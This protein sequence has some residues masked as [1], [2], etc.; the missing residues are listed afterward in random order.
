MASGIYRSLFP[1]VSHSGGRRQDLTFFSIHFGSCFEFA[2]FFLFSR[3]LSTSRHNVCAYTTCHYSAIC[4]MAR[5]SLSGIAVD[6]AGLSR[7]IDL[8]ATRHHLQSA[9]WVG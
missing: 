7:N 9:P 6:N 2:D 1:N 4:T 5:T 8:D 3:W